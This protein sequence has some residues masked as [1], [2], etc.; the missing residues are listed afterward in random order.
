[1]AGIFDLQAVQ[2]EMNDGASYNVWIRI[3]IQINSPFP[4]KSFAV[5]AVNPSAGIGKYKKAV[6]ICRTRIDKGPEGCGIQAV[7][8]EELQE[9]FVWVA[10]P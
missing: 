9:A 8:G 4:G 5:I 1:L 2:R 3:D 6:W 10:N 7:D